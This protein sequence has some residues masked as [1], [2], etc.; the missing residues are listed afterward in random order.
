MQVS[1]MV[2]AVFDDPNLIGHAGLVPVL[3]LAQRA[4]LHD[5]V[6]AHLSVPSPNLV[7]KTSSVIAGMLCGADSIDDLDV[8]RHGGMGRVFDGRAGTVD[9]GTFLRSFTF[10]HVRQLDAVNTRLL[11]SLCGLVDAVNRSP[12]RAAGARAPGSPV[13]RRPRSARTGD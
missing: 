11:S 10:G 13:T 2:S 8:I 12:P 3:Q 6:G 4:G 1:H 5:L 7:A 9:V